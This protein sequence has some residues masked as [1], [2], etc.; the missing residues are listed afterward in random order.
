MDF[1]SEEKLENLF[2]IFKKN[3]FCSLIGRSGCGK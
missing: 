1:A 2:P 3:S